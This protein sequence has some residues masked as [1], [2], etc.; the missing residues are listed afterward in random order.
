MTDRGLVRPANEDQFLVAVLSK[1]MR[2]EHCSLPQPTTKC[3]NDQGHIFLVADGI[4]GSSAGER[5]S[6][7]AV[8]TI[9]DFLVNT[10]KCF[11]QLQATEKED[12]VAELQAALREAD[13][14]LFLEAAEHPELMGMG[15]TL[16]LGYSLNSDLFV[17]HAGDSRCYLNREGQLEQLTRDHTMA[18]ELAQHGLIRPDE[19]R[20]HP[21]RHVVTN[22]VGGHSPGVRVEVHKVHLQP[23][24]VLL[25]ATDGLTRMVPDDQISATLISEA[26]PR[27][28]CKRL[29]EQ[30]IAAGG[31]DNVTVIVARYHSVAA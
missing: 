12:V 29:V 30:A 26:E 5:A 27:V 13:A 14:R 4:G 22:A 6:A 25:F 7:L 24:D 16:T 8:W 1:A 10:L 21:M 28:A 23:D 11:F 9:E 18:E 20:R 2:V 17:V 31:K 3:G 15:T 19:V